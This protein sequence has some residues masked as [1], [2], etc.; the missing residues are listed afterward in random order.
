MSPPKSQFEAGPEQKTVAQNT[1][2][3][4]AF[5][6][7]VYNC[8]RKLE[9]KTD[10]TPAMLIQGRVSYEYDITYLAHRAA[11]ELNQAILDVMNDS[12]TAV[13][14]KTIINK[15]NELD[16]RLMKSGISDE[17]KTQFAQQLIAEIEK[18]NMP[19]SYEIAKELFNDIDTNKNHLMQQCEVNAYV[20]QNQKGTIL[21]ASLTELQHEFPIMGH[22]DVCACDI[23]QGS[24]NDLDLG[25]HLI[26]ADNPDTSSEVLKQLASSKDPY[27]RYGVAHSTNTPPE[28]LKQLASDKAPSVR[29]GVAY[30]T[31]TPPEVLKQL[32]SDKALSVRSG[33]ACN[34]NTPPDVLKQ[35]ASDKALSVR[36]GVAYNR[37]TP[38][39]V[40]QQ[41]ATD[42]DL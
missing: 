38:P 11:D 36:S 3:S 30:N 33:V 17:Q 9:P 1:S 39:D 25:E 22:H 4:D 40:V 8:G 14:K 42:Y 21:K 20:S 27:V 13:E 29:S 2:A 28:V 19:L 26:Y 23:K 32:A 34:T 5:V 31:N 10:S 15:I 35:L 37:N 12:K 6:H 41:L 7:Q 24:R 18:R 16:D